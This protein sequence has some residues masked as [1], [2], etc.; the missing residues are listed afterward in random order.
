MAFKGPGQ[1]KFFFAA[2]DDKKK[3]LNPMEQKT[4]ANPIDLKQAQAPLKSPSLNV[5]KLNNPTANPKPIP[6]LPGLPK[7]ARFAKMKK[8]FK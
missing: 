4:K 7:P 3:G 2:Q 6:A 5:P 1:R 8:Y